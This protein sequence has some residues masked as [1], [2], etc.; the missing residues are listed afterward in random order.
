MGYCI[1][2]LNMSMFCAQSQNYQHLIDMGIY[3]QI[4]QEREC[5]AI[6]EI[7]WQFTIKS[8]NYFFKKDWEF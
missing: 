4:F 8:T 3:K 7:L 6:F 5:N 2:Q 1:H